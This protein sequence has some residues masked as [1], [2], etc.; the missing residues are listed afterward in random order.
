MATTTIRIEA[1][2][3]TRVAA[4]AARAGKTTHAFI[5]GAI[6]ETVEQDEIDEAFHRVADERWS[7]F[8][9]TGQSVPWDET[10][11]WLEARARGEH[12]PRPAARRFER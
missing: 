2:L 11:V 8:L 3:K 5:L 6:A 9:A 7:K 1:D 4:A 10:K 12:Q